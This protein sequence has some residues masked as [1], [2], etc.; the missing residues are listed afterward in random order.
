MVGL[1][2]HSEHVDSGD[3]GTVANKFTVRLVKIHESA[4]TGMSF[5]CTTESNVPT[6]KCNDS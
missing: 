5:D 3:G 4:S 2:S 1:L 6:N